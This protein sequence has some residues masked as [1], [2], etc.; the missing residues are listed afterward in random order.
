MYD[1]YSKLIK[2]TQTIG[3]MQQGLN[4]RNV[5][6]LEKLQPAVEGIGRIAEELDKLRRSDGGEGVSRKE[7]Q[8]RELVRWVVGAPARFERYLEEGMRE[9]MESEWRDVSNALDK[10]HGVKGVE[11]IRSNCEEIMVKATDDAG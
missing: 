1:N 3:N 8:K 2:A 7:K 11:E 4:A 10:W 6:D 5:G 9:E